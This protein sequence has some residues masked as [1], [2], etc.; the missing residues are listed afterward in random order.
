MGTPNR[1]VV[2]TTASAPI[3][4]GGVRSV[5]LR[6]SAATPTSRSWPCAVAMKSV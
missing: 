4:P 6:M 2:P 1:W 3:S 5:R